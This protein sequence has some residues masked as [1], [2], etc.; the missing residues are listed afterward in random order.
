MDKIL[1]NSVIDPSPLP[2]NWQ[3]ILKCGLASPTLPSPRR[4]FE[5]LNPHAEGTPFMEQRRQRPQKPAAILM[6]IIERES[7]ATPS[8][9]FMLRASGMPSH[10]G[11]ISFPG[12]KVHAGDENRLA[13]ALRES[14]EEIGVPREKVNVLGILGEHFGGQGYR[15]TPVVGVVPES[16]PLKPCQREVETLFEVPLSHLLDLK[17][18]KPEAHEFNGTDYTMFAVHFDQWHIWGLTA[19]M[20]HTLAL[21]WAE[22]LALMGQK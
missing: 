17:N 2:G 19:G 12:G 8:V 5:E 4:L 22:G 21:A 15:V 3:A 14:E 1:Q 16:V 13:T 11:Q 9:V 6:P 20:I 7:A 18:H 10:P